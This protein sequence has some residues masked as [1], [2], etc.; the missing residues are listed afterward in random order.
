MGRKRAK[1][2]KGVKERKWSRGGEITPQPR[3][4]KAFP[5]IKRHKI[6]YE[7]G[8]SA[9]TTLNIGGE[10]LLNVFGVASS[11]TNVYFPI[12]AVRLRGVRVWNVSNAA[13][14]GGNSY[15]TSMRLQWI[16]AR[17]SNSEVESVQIGQTN[18]AYLRSRPPKNSFSSMW[19]DMNQ[20]AQY[21][22]VFFNL[23]FGPGSVVCD[24]EL[25]IQF[26]NLNAQAVTVTGAT[27]GRVYCT[28]LGGGS[29]G[30]DPLDYPSLSSL[31]FVEKNS[32]RTVR[33]NMLKEVR[34]E[35]KN[36]E[37]EIEK[38]ENGSSV[39]EEEKKEKKEKRKDSEVLEISSEQ[40]QNELAVKEINEFVSL[41]R[42]EQE[43]RYGKSQKLRDDVVT[44][45]PRIDRMDSSPYL[46]RCVEN[47]L[48][49]EDDNDDDP[50]LS[51]SVRL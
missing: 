18:I 4:I 15:F 17:G 21:T 37:N 9:A 13:S 2:R 30:L 8:Y 32:L 5:L 33:G 1:K 29:N 51:G 28:S 43:A 27:G 31:P 12:Q 47:L 34:E 22:E 35:R 14:S 39:E 41:K 3:K 16:S 26:A 25:D 48:K 11:S 40:L 23:S 24:I 38:K 10:D 45:I 36:E 19:I 7:A 42:K 49:D 20:S 44:K 50:D 46:L 6:R